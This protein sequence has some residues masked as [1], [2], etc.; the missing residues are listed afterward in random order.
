MKIEL[1]EQE[2][3]NVLNILAKRPYIEVAQVI[4]KISTQV[5]AQKVQVK[6]E[7]EK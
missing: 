2:I 1:S 5:Q 7:G 4:A 6:K 3:T